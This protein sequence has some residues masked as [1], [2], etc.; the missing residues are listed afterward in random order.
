MKKTWLL[1]HNSLSVLDYRCDA[2]PD[3]RPVVEVFQN[4]SLS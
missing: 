3:E 4:Y 2:G 1:T